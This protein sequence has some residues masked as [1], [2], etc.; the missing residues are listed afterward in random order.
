MKGNFK[1]VPLN[2][3]LFF[4]AYLT[5]CVI[6]VN[7]GFSETI[8]SGKE[9]DD[10]TVIDHMLVRIKISGTIEFDGQ[11]SKL[12]INLTVP[13]EHFWQNV[14]SSSSKCT[15]IKD[16]EGNTIC[17]II[18]T[19][20]TSPYTYSLEFEV[21]SS[22]FLIKNGELSVKYPE[23][24]S[25]YLQPTQNMQS[26]D[27][28]I[29]ALAQLI[30]KNAR[31][32]FEKVAK[33]AEWVY[34]NVEYD[35]S[36]GTENKD[37]LWVLNHKR[38]VCA[39]YTTLF[40]ALARAAGIPA[41]YVHVYA[42]GENG[43]E[44]HAI[45]EVYLGR[46][47]PVDTLWLEVGWIDATHIFFGH[48]HDN[49]IANNI[50]VEGRNIQN[51]VWKRDDI[52]FEVIQVSESED[53]DKISIFAPL[54]VLDFGGKTVVVAEIRSNSYGVDKLRMLPCEGI[55]VIDVDDSP[56]LVVEEPSQTKYIYWE[57]K[58]NKNLDPRYIY[59]CPLTLNTLF[60]NPKVKKI[61]IN[62][63]QKSVP[64]FVWS[65]Y[66]AKD[67]VS[68]GDEQ[69]VV[70]KLDRLD[71][72]SAKLFVG[73]ESFLKS[74]TIL[75]KDMPTE[76][77]ITFVPL[78]RGENS[79]YVF[80]DAG[81][82]FALKY[83]VKERGSAYIESVDLPPYVRVGDVAFMNITVINKK[84]LEGLILEI[85]NKKYETT[86]E[87]N[88]SISVQLQTSE[89]GRKYI[90]LK[91][92]SSEGVV[93]D[94][95]FVEYEVIVPPVIHLKGISTNKA[96]KTRTLRILLYST[97]RCTDV[98][99]FD[100]DGN[101]I[102]GADELKEGYNTI[103]FETPERS[104]EAILKCKDLSGKEVSFTFDLNPGIIQRIFFLISAIL[105]NLKNFV[106]AIL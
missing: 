13:S 50:R 91:L 6:V 52:E 38:G 62:V 36:Y 97:G 89:E 64:A 37:A 102:G 34:E 105:E 47:V 15:W 90:K 45:A 77:H 46:W 67:F 42:Y 96:G 29:K 8:S 100:V 25:S 57:I 23:D 22:K 32:D 43:W 48:Y 19:N 87:F 99:V 3:A 94:E 27:E 53:N 82:V 31:D 59:S 98:R 17:N 65:A 60:N 104:K 44:S 93:M 5:A 4:V 56:L 84:R 41:R 95:K 79:V 101:L 73:D 20:P 85:G 66:T 61:V 70:I 14:R 51:I 11:A 28:S 71:S 63:T 54:S 1:S 49:R 72:K 55:N 39:E 83:Y 10:P 92:L 69:G 103:N 81:H 21:E 26:D 58:A 2:L 18:E 75:K 30:T 78:K 68:F 7:I 74:Y 76:I 16:G 88:T 24:V 9:I 33:I 80:D 12:E 106:G 40:I 86:P 35:A